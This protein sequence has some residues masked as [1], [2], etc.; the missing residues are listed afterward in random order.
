M[1]LLERMPGLRQSGDCF[2]RQSGR[3][4]V[5][6]DREMELIRTAEFIAKNSVD[7]LPYVVGQQARILAGPS[8]DRLARISRAPNELSCCSTFSA[9]RCGS[10]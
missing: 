7:G 5:L 8:G 10:E 9:G 2:M 4:V 3:P 1:Q 6:T